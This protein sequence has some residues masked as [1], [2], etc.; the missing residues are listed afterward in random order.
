MRHFFSKT[1]DYKKIMK[2]RW[3]FDKLLFKNYQ[4]ERDMKYN[5]CEISKK[6]K[7][8]KKIFYINPEYVKFVNSNKHTQKQNFSKQGY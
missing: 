4:Q 6:F 8:V 2:E 7:K 3:L 5:N 1:I